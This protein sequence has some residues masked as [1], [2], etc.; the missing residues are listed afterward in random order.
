MGTTRDMLEAGSSNYVY[1]VAIE[2]Y[3][4]LL[5]SHSSS[6]AVLTAWAGTDWSAAIGGLT[7]GLSLSQ[8]LNP[9]EPFGSMGTCTLM[10]QAINGDDSFG[11]ATH[12]RVSSAETYLAETLDRDD[13]TV[14]VMS[15]SLFAASG[16]I[17]IG[18]ECIAFAGKDADSFNTCTRGMYSP[19]GRS[20]SA[21]FARDHAVRTDANSV[22]LQPRVTSIPIAWKGR[23]VGVWAHRVVGGVLDTKAEA[24]LV[25]AGTLGDVRDDREKA[26]T[27]VEVRSIM[28]WVGARVLGDGMLE[29]RIGD[30]MYLSE[31]MVFSWHETGTSGGSPYD[32]SVADILEV[33]SGASGVT[34]I[35]PGFYSGS[36]ICG[37]I[38]AWL[39]ADPNLGGNY[40]LA[41]PV[42]GPDGLRTRISYDLAL[43]NGSR[44]SVE[45]PVEVA[46][47][48]GW[49]TVNSGGGEAPGYV[50]LDVTNMGVGKIYEDPSTEPMRTYAVLSGSTLSARVNIEATTGEL[51]DQ[52]DRLPSS[53]KPST[54]LVDGVL[55]YWGIFVIGDSAPLLAAWDPDE[56]TQLVGI[57]E[58][59]IGGS[60]VGAIIG[61]VSGAVTTTALQVGASEGSARVRQMYAYELPFS[62]LVFTMF[63]STGTSSYNVPFLDLLPKQLS[64]GMPLDLL[65]AA[66]LDEV[67]G[68]S[69]T[70][71]L[72]LDKPTRLS[73]LI[74]SDLVFR[75]AF[76]VWQ[77][78][79]IRFRSWRAPSLLDAIADVDDT[80]KAEPSGVVASHATTTAQTDQWMRTVVKIKFDRS[81]ANPDDDTYKSVVTFYDRASA[82]DQGG[83]V[84]IHTYELANTF[85]E[86]AATG[87]STESLLPQYLAKM[88]LLSRPVWLVERSI[89]PA[90]F[91]RL[92]VGDIVAF[93]D[94]YARDP[95]TGERG[96][97]DRAAL[98]THLMLEPSGLGARIRM[99][100]T[101][102]DTTRSGVLYAPAA[103]VDYD[104]S[105][106][107]F[108]AGY[109]DGDKTLRTRAHDYSNAAEDADASHFDAGDVVFIRERDPHDPT[110]PIQ[111]QR[112]VD[113]Q[114]G[115]D[116]VLTTTLSSPAWDPTR[117]YV[118]L[119]AD[120]SD[121]QSAQ[122][123]HTFQADDTTGLVETT[124]LPYLYG[125][126]NADTA[127]ANE[128]LPPEIPSTLTHADG[129]GRCTYGDLQ[130]ARLIDNFLDYKAPSRSH[131][132]LMNAVENLDAV[133]GSGYKLA[134]YWPVFLNFEMLSNAIFRYITCAVWA[135]STD[136]TE[137]KVRVR[138]RRTQ[139]T[140]TSLYNIS[141]ASDFATAEWTGIT[142]TTPTT[143]A[144]VTTLTVNVKNTIFAGDN[145]GLAYVTLELG[146]KAGTRGISQWAVGARQAI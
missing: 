142:S 64:V 17:H 71:V 4:K 126:G 59:K 58:W 96:I 12:R 88:P 19:F 35:E 3:S 138:L 97:S 145:F 34:E 21:R 67:P 41:T 16:E 139:P 1:V 49:S 11:I 48:F 86:F 98:I 27:V 100:I 120:Y 119:F 111:W 115:N 43:D 40:S 122:K 5:H 85:E 137:T 39:A 104:A 90:M 54:N 14:T 108:S 113:S 79:A 78:G 83:A 22:N 62:T 87:A 66:F 75:W 24:E 136:G 107:G 15:T 37:F 52:Y 116:I 9:D 31:G 128:D 124:A 46:R 26:R 134:A 140:E 30:G 118:V 69:E 135:Y 117:K 130:L 18:T 91:W 28:E 89:S 20:G 23:F 51:V 29:A 127:D 81:F 132:M 92:C 102:Q 95:M 80:S 129:A 146:H 70:S 56:P 50:Q 68:Y 77:R 10:V 76:A 42:A 36:E 123:A 74:K 65:G 63:A 7:V 2:G 32:E 114:S 121:T 73:D 131:F 93:S 144:S 99:L 57:R 47:F 112:T 72:V 61:V 143:L 45:L 94:P 103:N 105:P 106:S 44:F 82:D 133:T 13:T 110:N 125:S 101:E 33:V 8:S 53:I 55:H 6:A 109:N 84:K 25:F 60:L 141:P 38:N